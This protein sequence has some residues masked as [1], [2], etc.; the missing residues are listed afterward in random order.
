MTEA[1]P[2]IET[3]ETEMF[4]EPA[5]VIGTRIGGRTVWP[6]RR[7]GCRMARTKGG[8]LVVYSPM[9]MGQAMTMRM[10]GLDGEGG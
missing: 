2:P 8:D 1:P 10:L 6:S 3:M 7:S 4:G 5:V 9:A